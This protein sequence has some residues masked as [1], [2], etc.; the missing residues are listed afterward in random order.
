MPLHYRLADLPARFHKQVEEQLSSNRRNSVHS[1][2]T[3]KSNAESFSK[4]R[5]DEITLIERDYKPSIIEKPP[6]KEFHGT[7]N[8]TESSYNHEVL[9][10]NG[11]YEAVTIKLPGGNYTPDWMTIDDGVVTFHEVK[12]GYR[13][14]S[15]SRAILAFKEA[16]AF[17][18]FWKFVWAQKQKGGKWIV[19]HVLNSKES[20]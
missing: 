18:P 10:D 8:K 3:T 14:A 13:F 6:I 1:D 12:G 4:K 5:A 2:S 11:R 19:K 20:S 15:E 17:C 7:P 16:A 9:H